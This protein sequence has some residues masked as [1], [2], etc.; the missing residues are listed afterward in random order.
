[1]KTPLDA[2][3][4]TE[5]NRDAIT[6][7]IEIV[8]NHEHPQKIFLT[9]GEA[10][11]KTLLLR[12]RAMEKNLLSTKRVSYRPAW[13]LT[14]AVREN[15]WDGFFEEIG[16]YEVLFVD[17]FEGLLDDQEVGPLLFKLL[18]QERNSQKLD[19]VVAS[20]APMAEL[21]LDA[22][23]GALDGFEEL[24]LAPLDKDGLKALAIE[25]F[26]VYHEEGTTPDIS[27]DA[28]SY[29]ASWADGPAS[30]RRALGLALE[31]SEFSSEN[32]IDRDAMK[33]LVG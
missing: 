21:E 28:F 10:T 22:F 23:E 32:T 18:M 7:I 14:K 29:L 12:A 16:S 8:E 2:L 20:R 31:C 11:G 4:T 13:E 3:I 5:E 15:A 9:G 25:L 33:R 27:D 17:D 19:T 26:D 30:L 1:M 6:R 24:V